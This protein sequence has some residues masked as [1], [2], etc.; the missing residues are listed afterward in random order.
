MIIRNAAKCLLC[1]EVIESKYRHDYRACSCGNLHV[2]GGMDYIRRVC[3]GGRDSVEEMNV[4][5]AEEEIE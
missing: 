5:E 2:D 1:G 3:R 4:F